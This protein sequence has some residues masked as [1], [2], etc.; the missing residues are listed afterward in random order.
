[1]KHENL[2]KRTLTSM[3]EFFGTNLTKQKMELN[4]LRVKQEFLLNKMY[5]YNFEIYKN[6]SKEWIFNITNIKKL[7]E[8]DILLDYIKTYL[9]FRLLTPKLQDRFKI[10]YLNDYES[11]TSMENFKKNKTIDSR[12]QHLQR[13]SE[14][15]KKLEKVIAY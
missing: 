5:S 10:D 9:D 13:K 14:S 8:N 1:M 12:T 3:N 15:Q 7:T 2:P 11:F 6:D 4:L